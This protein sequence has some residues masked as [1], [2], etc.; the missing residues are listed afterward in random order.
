MPVP[1]GRRAVVVTGASG[2]VGR[3]TAVA[4]G[5]KGDRVALLA[6]GREGLAAAADEVRRAGGEALVVPVDVADAKAVDDAAQ[7]VVDTFGQ[8]DVW[9]NNAFTGVFA[10][11]TEITADEFRRVTEVT[12]L[13]YV[14]GTRAALRH[15]LPRDRGT[16]VQV[17]SALAY[18]GIPLQSAYC[19]AKHAI[20]GFN[21]SLRCE[22]LHSGTGVRTTMVQM[23]GLNTPQFDWVL[24]RMPGKARPVAPV[25]QPEV[26]A[27]AILHAAA[28]GRR[29]EYWV[30]GSTV[31]TL[32]AN[33]VAPGI[34]DR[35]LARTAFDS[36]Q[37]EGEHGG[38]SN[39]WA[40]VD[41][42]HGRDFGAHGRFDDEAVDDSPQDWVSR[43]RSRMGA[44]LVVAGLGAAVTTGLRRRG[45]QG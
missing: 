26:A 31:A 16:I 3:A 15:M 10:P 21:E 5:A 22:L 17:G 18:R 37:E 1:R 38:P 24:N 27:R 44:G 42:V 39:L 4:F 36:Q 32:L 2:G 8:I 12:Y 25:Y 9:V 30:G 13:G 23:P 41:G 45:R 34:L 33:A 29:R 11:V 6:R 35:Y 40:P 28:H 14:F 7:Q 20:Q 43:N 19:G